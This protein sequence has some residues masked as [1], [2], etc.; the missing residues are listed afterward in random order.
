MDQLLTIRRYLSEMF[1][2]LQTIFFSIKHFVLK[3]KHIL[4]Q[5]KS[6]QNQMPL[7]ELNLTMVVAIHLK[8]EKRQIFMKLTDC[9][10]VTTKPNFSFSV[11]SN[12]CHLFF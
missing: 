4:E 3:V 7:L 8:I 5:E 11:L 10:R 9:F 6:H 1:R 12:M 2:T